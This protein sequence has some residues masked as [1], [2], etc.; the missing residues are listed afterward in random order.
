MSVREYGV[1]GMYLST[2]CGVGRRGV[3]RVIELPLDE[4]EHHGLEASAD[5]LAPWATHL[6]PLRGLRW[7]VS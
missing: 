1:E 7:H 5:V 3:E 2:P 4:A 6:S